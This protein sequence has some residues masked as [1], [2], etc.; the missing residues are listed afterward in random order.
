[1]VSLT[2]YYGTLSQ[3][4]GVLVVLTAVV[5]AFVEPIPGALLAPL[6][7]PFVTFLVYTSISGLVMDDLRTLSPTLVVVAVGA[8]Y[9]LVPVTA[10][11]IGRLLLAPAELAGVVVLSAGPTTAGSALAWTRLS[12]A[13]VVLAAGVTFG[14]LLVSPLATPA[15]VGWFLGTVTTIPVVPLLVE[16]SVVVAGGV[17]LSRLVPEGTLTDRQRN[18]SSLV[19]VGALVYTGVTTSPLS[20][21]GL[22]GVA[23][24][25]LV[26][27]CVT[28][29]VFLTAVALDPLLDGRG[30]RVRA[31]FFS[32]GLKNLGVAVLVSSAVR[33]EGATLAV[34]TYY[35]VQQL[36]AGTVVARQR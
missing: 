35:V 7:V 17:A 34:V 1:M 10:V 25:A 18:S 33:Y 24:V 29:L 13:D 2:G 20:T 16:L 3:F 12:D 30:T 22:G 19:V 26:A 14:T 11:G 6:V 27:L 5:V 36:V 31:L 32:I 9:L 23:R 15:L 28:L 21:A 4:R 8:A